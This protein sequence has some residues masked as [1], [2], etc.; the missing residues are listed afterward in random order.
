MNVNIHDLVLKTKV[1]T[2]GILNDTNTNN[3]NTSEDNGSNYNEDNDI[4]N[5][6]QN[7]NKS[8]MIMKMTIISTIVI[9]L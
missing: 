5:Y 9:S 3:G 8:L 1:T 2:T 7:G 4:H 6:I